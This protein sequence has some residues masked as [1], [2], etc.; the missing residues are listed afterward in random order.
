MPTRSSEIGNPERGILAKDP[1]LTR[2]QWAEPTL[3]RLDRI[4]RRKVL[5]ETG[6]LENEDGQCADERL[7]LLAFLYQLLS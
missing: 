6:V 4:K 3:L 5:E 7:K 1:N 2:V